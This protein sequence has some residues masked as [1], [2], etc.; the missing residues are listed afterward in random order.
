MTLATQRSH[1][2]YV[3]YV[4]VVLGNFEE[5]YDQ[6]G[7]TF[8]KVAFGPLLDYFGL[9]LESLRKHSGIF[10]TSLASHWGVFWVTLCHFGVILRIN[11]RSP[12][13]NTIVKLRLFR[14]KGLCEKMR[15]RG[16]PLGCEG[17]GGDPKK[18][19]HHMIF[20]TTRGVH[21]TS[22][23]CDGSIEQ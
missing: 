18:H 11:L 2:P 19:E 13:N 12:A 4:S 1:R 8:C 14:E 5:F 16:G 17:V 15:W 22:R 21:M 10:V 23:N 7:A 6:F 3:G 20:P 9:T